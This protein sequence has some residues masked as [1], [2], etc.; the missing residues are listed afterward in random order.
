MNGQSV[1]PDYRMFG[2]VNGGFPANMGIDRQCSNS[3]PENDSN[4]N[5]NDEVFVDNPSDKNDNLKSNNLAKSIPPLAASTMSSNMTSNMSMKN[6]TKSSD[7]I[8][9]YP[10]ELVKNSSVSYGND[11]SNLILKERQSTNAVEGAL[12]LSRPSSNSSS[13]NGE[14]KISSPNS[15]HEKSRNGSPN[16]P[17]ITTPLNV[18]ASLASNE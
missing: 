1:P 16:A 5:D 2:M 13:S 3:E 14:G 7:E 18:L 6:Q 17:P 11:S 15:P 8:T 9:S 4:S 10:T 12:D